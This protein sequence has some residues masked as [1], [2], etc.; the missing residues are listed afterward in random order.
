MKIEKIAKSNIED[1]REYF[2]GMADQGKVLEMIDLF[3]EMLSKLSDRNTQLE[4][5]L[6]LLKKNI[7]GRR[8]ETVPHE[9]LKLFAQSETPVAPDEPVLNDPPKEQ[10][11]ETGKKHTGG[12]RRPIPDTVPREDQIIAVDGPDRTCPTCGKEKALMGYETS[13]TL[14]IIPAHFKVIVHKREKLVC[15]TC[16]DGVVVAPVPDKMIE[17]GLPGPGLM[18]EIITGKYKDHLPVHRLHERFKRLGVDIPQSTMTGWISQVAEEMLRPIAELQRKKV[19]QSVVLQ[20]DDTGI[21]VQD[22]KHPGNIFRGY[23]WFYVG[24]GRDV[25]VDFTPG[26]GRDGPS[27]FLKGRIGG[28]LQVDGYS[29]YDKL[30]KDHTDWTEVGCWMHARRYFVEAYESKDFRAIPIIENIKRLYRIEAEAREA[31]L[32]PDALKERREKDS[33]PVLTD[34]RKWL[35][36]HIPKETPRSLLGKAMAYMSGRW[37][38]LTRFVTD[39][40]IPIDNGAVERAIR[41]VAV[42]RKNYLFAGS[43]AGARNAAVI[44]GILSACALAEVP[45]DRYFRDVL[46]KIAGGW[47][48]SRLHELLPYEWKHRFLNQS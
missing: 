19:L 25:Y 10:K 11:P 24:D 40:R 47:L 23:Y 28:Y 17:R 39:G 26:R 13:E 34:I 30:F 41:P 6:F 44:Y 3:I 33:I 37:K 12:G 22:R 46:E 2:A 32:G 21:K 38:A 35:T 48:K 20:T 9:Q 16:Q 8:S 42:G 4:Q 43:D 1:I 5:Q 7:Y 36:E 31:A 18:T 15:K 29:V 27:A 45:P 14:E